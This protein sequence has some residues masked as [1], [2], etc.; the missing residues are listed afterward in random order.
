[1]DSGQFRVQDVICNKCFCQLGW[2][3][4]YAFDRAPGRITPRFL[5]KKVILE[6]VKIQRGEQNNRTGKDGVTNNYINHMMAS[7]GKL[8]IA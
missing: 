4:E 8:F 6:H 3:Y 5:E 2:F 1:M 7:N